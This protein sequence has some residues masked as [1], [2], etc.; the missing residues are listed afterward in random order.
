MALTNA[1]KQKLYRTRHYCLDPEIPIGTHTILHRLQTNLDSQSF[2]NLE[3][4]AKSTGMNKREIIEKA[5]NELAERLDC[6][7]DKD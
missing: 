6:N 2:R 5:I 1:E 7:H 4:L 3:R